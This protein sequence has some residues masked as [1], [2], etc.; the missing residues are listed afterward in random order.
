MSPS[1]LV[2][3]SG[4]STA[5]DTAETGIS[6]P[7]SSFEEKH[8]GDVFLGLASPLINGFPLVLAPHVAIGVSF[9][10]DAVHT[11]FIVLSDRVVVGSSRGRL[12]IVKDTG[13]Q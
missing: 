7:A 11:L 3:L 5:S 6:L 2:V 9:V 10:S 12:R 1:V 8:L 4:G 13:S